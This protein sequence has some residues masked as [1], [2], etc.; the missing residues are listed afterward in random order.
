VSERRFLDWPACLNARDVGGYATL[1]GRHSRWG[2]LVRADDLCRLTPAGRAAVVGY[3][4]R[5][6]VD[7]RFPAEVVRRPH[8]FA[9]GAEGVAYRNI[10]VTA[11]RDTADD[12]AIA[13][14]FAGA[15]TR[16]EANALELDVNRPGFAGILAA[17]AAA[18]EGAVVVHCG[19]GKDRTGIAIA[20]AL[21][22]VGLPDDLIAA[23]YALSTARLADS[24]EREIAARG[25]DDPDALAG[26]RQQLSSRPETMLTTLAHLREQHGGAEAYLIAGGLTRPEIARLRR[27]LLA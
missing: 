5:T 19:S 9:S 22:L 3:G 12:E 20:L 24:Y 10:P 25:V 23:D 26:L 2:A 17:V 14:R 7:V 11:G 6:I 21:S 18:P 15:R 4:V 1:D 8:P 27:R 13:A 16:E